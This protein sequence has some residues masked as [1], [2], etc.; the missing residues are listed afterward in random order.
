M[1]ARADFPATGPV[2]DLT[3]TFTATHG[4]IKGTVGSHY[5]VACVLGEFAVTVKGQ[6]VAAGV[7]DCQALR[8][9][10]ADWRIAS[11]P[12][13]AAAPCAWPGSADAVRAGY[14]ALS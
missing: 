7:G 12:L 8:W 3:A 11:G 6:T 9:S 5:V 10:G 1:R 4:Q 14:R 13:A 2:P